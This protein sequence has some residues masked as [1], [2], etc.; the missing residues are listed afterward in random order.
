MWT[1]HRTALVL[2]LTFGLNRRGRPDTTTAAG[3]LGV[4]QRSVQRWLH[5]EPDDRPHISPAHHRDLWQLSRPAEPSLRQEELT[6]AHARESLA[7]IK[8]PKRRGILAAWRHQ[9]WLE[10][11][12]VGVLELPQLGVRQVAVSRVGDRTVQEMRRR[13]QVVDFTVVDTRFHATVLTHALLR[14]LDPWRIQLP[15][16]LVKQGHTRA[17]TTDAPTIDLDHLAV[18]EGLR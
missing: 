7:R 5:G 1:V 6:A 9:R 14:R 4:S 8:L 17:W 18:T 10:P 16:G 2:A 11:H 13:G 3:A 15:A 12:M